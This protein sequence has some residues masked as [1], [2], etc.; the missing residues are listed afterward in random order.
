MANCGRIHIENQI[1]T[2]RGKKSHAH[3]MVEVCVYGVYTNGLGIVS[4]VDGGSSGKE[5]HTFIPNSW[6]NAI[7]RAHIAGSSKGSR[8]SDAAE[9][10]PGW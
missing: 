7:S 9:E 8:E 10:P 4:N 2:C 5:G 1:N 6:N 3:V